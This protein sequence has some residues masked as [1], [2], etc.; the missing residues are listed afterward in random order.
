MIK[1]NVL[2]EYKSPNSAAF[3]LPLISY[4]HDLKD[5]GIDIKIIYK[6]SSDIFNCD[7]LFINS[8]F[9]RKDWGEEG[10]KVFSFLNQAKSK[11][12]YVAWFD[13]TDSTGTCQFQVLPYVDKYYKSQLLKD[14]NLYTQKMYGS[15]IYTDYYHKSNSV[16]D[17]APIYSDIDFNIEYLDKLRVSWNSGLGHYSQSLIGDMR[18]NVYRNSGRMLSAKIPHSWVSPNLDREIDFSAR[19]GISY[20]RQTVRYQREQIKKLI[21]EIS[22]LPKLTRKKYFS[23]LSKSKLMIAPFGFGEIT[24]IEFEGFISGCLILKPNMQHI[25]TWPNFY[26]SDKTIIEHEWDLSDFIEKLE[27][28][29]SKYSDYLDVARNGQNVYKKYVNPLTGVELFVER[30]VAILSDIKDGIS[31]ED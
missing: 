22:G 10:A 15:R 27:D 18:K 13:I 1:V 31:V 8:K 21:P 4:K 24:L 14:K 9:F 12:N 29:Y 7:V 19:F 6:I 11:T 30:I 23:E 2:T 16:T 3:N 25:E 20:K 26:L 17:E 28:C 5:V